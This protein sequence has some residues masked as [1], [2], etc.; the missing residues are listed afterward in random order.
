MLER[1]EGALLYDADG[2]EYLDAMSGGLFAVLA[3]YAGQIFLVV[4]ADATAFPDLDV[5]MAGTAQDWHALKGSYTAAPIP[6]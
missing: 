4:T 1:G 2:R 6:E 3:G 5:P